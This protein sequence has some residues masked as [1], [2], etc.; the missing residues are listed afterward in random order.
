MGNSLSGCFVVYFGLHGAH[1][2]PFPIQIHVA[3]IQG[4][5]QQSLAAM[6]KT[7]KLGNLLT[8]SFLIKGASLYYLSDV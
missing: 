4:S 5:K 1:K 7:L 2:V 8:C 3:L 6:Y